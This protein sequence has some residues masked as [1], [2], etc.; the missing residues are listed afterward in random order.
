[1]FKEPD[2]YNLSNVDCDESKTYGIQWTEYGGGEQA[3]KISMYYV[4][5]IDSILKGVAQY[6]E[7]R[8]DCR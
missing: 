5:D 2:M 4:Y 8:H 7:E 3:T 6:E 1:L